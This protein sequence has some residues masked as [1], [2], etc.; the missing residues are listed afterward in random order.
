V[1]EVAEAGQHSKAAATR[2]L[3]SGRE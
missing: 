1:A 2:V 3:R